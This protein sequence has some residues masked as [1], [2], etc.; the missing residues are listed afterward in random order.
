MGH[1]HKDD[2]KAISLDEIIKG[3]KVG[4]ERASMC[5]GQALFVFIALA[6]SLGKEQ[7]LNKMLMNTR[8]ILG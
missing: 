4:R 6:L 2:I 7:P 5:L 3:E 8:L 1:Q